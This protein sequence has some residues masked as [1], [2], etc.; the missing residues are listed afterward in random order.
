LLLLS[1]QAQS[2]FLLQAPN[3]GDEANYR[4]YEASDPASVL[5]TDFFYEATQPGIYFATYDGTLCGSN[6]TDYFILTDCNSPDNQV[7]LDITANVNG[8]ASVSWTPA[9]SG[10]QLQPQV[11]ASQT[12][13]RYTARISKAGNTTELPSFVVV[14]MQ[15][16]AELFDD[17]F[18]LNEDTSEVLPIFDND[19]YLPQDGALTTTD[20]SNGTISIDDNGTPNDPTDDV[21]TYTPDPDFNGADSFDYTVCNTSGDCSTATVTITVLPI[22]DAIDD[23]IATLE[24][25]PVIIDILANDNDIPNTGTLTL[26]DPSNG[27]VIIDDNGTPGDPSD[28]TVVYTPED[29][30]VGTDTFTYTLCDASGNCSTATVTIIVNM[31]DVDIDSDDDG[32]VDRFEDL[33]L[34]GDNDPAT[35]PVDTDSDGIPDY[36]DIDSDNDGIPDNV[37]A[38]TTGGYLPPLNQ[39]LNSNGL[40]DAYENGGSVGLIPQ[41]TDGDGLPDYVD[42]DSDDD[43][44]PDAIEGHDWDRDGFPD[45]VILGS[46]QDNDG[47][48]DGYEGNETV[49]VDVNDEID[50]PNSDLPDTDSDGEADYRDIDDDGDRI[51]TAS[52]D[53]NGDG[54]FSNDDS[55]GDG[56]PDY[57]DAS[58]EGDGVVVYNAVTP[59]GDGAYDVLTIENIENFPNNSVRIY[60]R[61]GVLVFSTRA[62]NTQGNTFDGTSE[63]R[64]T[65]ARDNKLPTGTYFY[66]LEYETTDGVMRQQTGYLYLNR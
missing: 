15:Q 25:Q 34:D 28:D 13:V 20:P 44:V 60:N 10:D 66:I 1:F 9:I 27:T 2:Q 12:V 53:S 55:D 59:N 29:D 38:Q 26:T 19:T 47:L 7:I 3:S 6:A 39:D 11:I 51:P 65:V 52:E 21:L 43:G 45:V 17:V 42:P 64:A 22:V 49:D 40:D 24:E 33:D 63:G 56:I 23:A 54:I 5:G 30:F 57:L 16:A 46:D 18:T 4:W 50:N 62:Y 41:D 37:E 35:N 36:L 32:I 31:A 48:D 14:C 58:A 8:S 61:W